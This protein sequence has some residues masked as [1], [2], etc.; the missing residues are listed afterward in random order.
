MFA[1]RRLLFIVYG[2]SRT[3]PVDVYTDGSAFT[4]VFELRVV[5]RVPEP[6][7]DR[8]DPFWGLLDPD[9]D[10]LARG[11]DLD[12]PIIKQKQQEIA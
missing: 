4:N 6:D 8:L 12:P 2:S 3:A 9:P 10:L 1:L 5:G 7:L 11:T